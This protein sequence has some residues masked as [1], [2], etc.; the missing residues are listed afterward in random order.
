MR[1]KALS[2]ALCAALGGALLAGGCTR[3][4]GGPENA[5]GSH[6]VAQAQMETRVFQVC[7]VP[8]EGKL[9]G[10][11]GKRS[12]PPEPIEIKVQDA[13]AGLS[14]Q[15]ILE[16]VK[17]EKGAVA[18]M[19]SAKC[20]VVTDIPE[21]LEAMERLINRLDRPPKQIQLSVKLIVL[22]DADAEQVRTR[23]LQKTLTDREFPFPGVLP[24]EIGKRTPKDAQER[25]ALGYLDFTELL[26][27]LKAM[28]AR[29]LGTCM[30]APQ[31]IICDYEEAVIHVSEL[32]RYS[33]LR[34]VC[35]EGGKEV[36]G[37]KLNG[38]PNKLG[39]QILVTPQ[40]KASDSSVMLTVMPEAEPPK[41]FDAGPL[42]KLKLPQTNRGTG[43][44]VTTMM[45]P[46]GKTAVVSG[47]RGRWRVDGQSSVG[48][49]Q[50]CRRPRDYLQPCS[51]RKRELQL[52]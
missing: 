51:E 29:R 48:K 3:T 31:C 32:T 2:T 38:S 25:L 47:L 15:Q 9:Y 10:P 33:V 1:E 26:T 21:K 19:Q 6:P 52:P 5:I 12:I 8:A 44:A 4:A 50:A 43:G 30:Q 34:V 23:V 27:F 7:Y 41:T 49:V 24:G 22:S 16:S 28:A 46:D 40:V 18:G 20:V 11:P 39:V 36:L 14:L 42:G 45:V 17:S 37:S 35:I 13:W